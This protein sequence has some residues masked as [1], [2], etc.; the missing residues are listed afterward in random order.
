MTQGIDTLTGEIVEAGQCYQLAPAMSVKQAVEQKKQLTQFIGEC[1]ERDQDFGVIPGTPKPT[2]LKPGA[3]KLA[4]FYGLT[5]TFKL[6]DSTEDWTGEY[7]NGEPFFNF[8]YRCEIE[9][10][11]LRIADCEGSCNSWESKYR[12]RNAFRECPDCGQPAIIKGKAEYG[13][14]WVCFKK[15]GG[16]G[17]K[18]MDGDP[19]IENQAQGKVPNEDIFSQVNTLQK[20][21]QKRAFVGAI[22]LAVNASDHF[23]HDIE[24]FQKRPEPEYTQE[25]PPEK[26]EAP[27]VHEQTQVPVLL[28]KPIAAKIIGAWGKLSVAQETLEEVAGKVDTWTDETRMRFLDAHERIKKQNLAPWAALQKSFGVQLELL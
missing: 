28:A 6:M 10:R 16:C 23:T 19:A 9:H 26:K 18:F 27:P 7:H 12:Y 17:A 11:G 13:G 24:D 22:C 4:T 2:L 3:E 20:Q 5:K 21:S 1:L 14:G 25:A 15:K 8:R